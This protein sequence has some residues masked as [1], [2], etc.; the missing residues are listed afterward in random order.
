MSLAVILQSETVLAISFVATIILLG[1]LTFMFGFGNSSLAP[2]SKSSNNA[3]QSS[4]S[5][6]WS[7]TTSKSS[8]KI[9]ETTVKAAVSTPIV[10]QPVSVSEKSKKTEPVAAK[11]AEP[12]AVAKNQKQP[13]Q[14]PTKLVE[15]VVTTKKTDKKQVKSQETVAVASKSVEQ[16]PV[17]ADS[18]GKT[19][20]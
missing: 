4:S 8:K 13:Q 15:T 20:L 14:K 3:E 19:L 17:D 9:K 7:K 11:K 16:V 10:T 12:A 1:L 2:P 18:S 5:T 6:K